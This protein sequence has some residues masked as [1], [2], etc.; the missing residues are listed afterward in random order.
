MAY[1]GCPLR[2]PV[3]QVKSQLGHGHVTGVTPEEDGKGDAATNARLSI[4]PNPSKPCEP[5]QTHGVIMV[6]PLI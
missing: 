6:Y 4:T 5:I 3:S 1:G 2:S